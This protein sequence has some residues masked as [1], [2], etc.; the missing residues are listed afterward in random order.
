MDGARVLIKLFAESCSLSMESSGENLCVYG[1]GE[2]PVMV[3]M[4]D[5]MKQLEQRGKVIPQDPGAAA[6]SQMIQPLLQMN[7][8]IYAMLPSFCPNCP[9]RIVAVER[10]L[11]QLRKPSK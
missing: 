2:C 10:E 8:N 5:K 4:G 6:V 9:K 11:A 7:A 3:I 1:L